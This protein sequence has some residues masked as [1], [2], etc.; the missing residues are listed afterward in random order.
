MY[1]SAAFVIVQAASL[2]FEALHLGTWPLTVVVVSAIVGFPMVLV[3]AWTF[4]FSSEG[5][6]RTE[7]REAGSAQLVQ[8]RGGLKHDLLLVGVVAAA[9]L[10]MGWVGWN[11]WLEPM[12]GGGAEAPAEEHSFDPRRMAVSYFEDHSP[13]A[14]LGYLARGLT[15]ALIHELD[16]IE[17]LDV[18]SPNGVKRYRGADVTPDSVARALRIGS[19]VEGSIQGTKDQIRVRAQLL[20]A[21]T[22]SVLESV[23]ESRPLGELFALQDDVVARVVEALRTRLGSI[24]RQRER[25]R[26][27]ESVEAWTLLQ[28]AEELQDRAERLRD[29]GDD[30]AVR[31]RL[32]RADSLLRRAAVLDSGWAAPVVLRGHLALSR[33]DLGTSGPMTFDRDLLRRAVD[34]AEAA[35]ERSPGHLGALE[36]RGMA[37]LRMSLNPHGSKN[38]RRL[39]EEDLRTVVDED[40]SRARAW[41]GLSALLRREGRFAEASLAAER[42]FEADQYLTLSPTIESAVLRRQYET[43]LEL[44]DIDAAREWCLT[45]H[46]EFPALSWTT[47]CKLFTLAL[48]GEPNTDRAWA[49]FD[50]LIAVTSD[51]RKDF[52]RGVGRM[53]V[54]SVIARSARQVDSSASAR[55]GPGAA[56]GERTPPAKTL[57]DSAHAVIERAR[58]VGRGQDGLATW[59]NYYEAHAR[60]Q[61]EER[62][63]A[64]A[65]IRRYLEARPQDAD[66]LR[67]DWILGDLQSDPRFLQLLDEVSGSS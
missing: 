19:L 38:V 64:L 10:G 24:V 62:D 48:A 43:N 52:N 16:R 46:R 51:P 3:V 40:A 1:A 14:D 12:R 59:L 23:E 67:V 41:N 54:A 37:R 6:K 35:L 2:T 44:A 22:G 33:A 15:D 4:E 13:D 8:P 53:W 25:Q 5:L 27:T 56:T 39:A 66:H 9:S 31:S 18:V 32:T 30:R 61:L 65:L 63:S 17:P 47:A 58:G 29:A 36:L 50:S 21:N 57:A 11:L 28:R 20:D 26:E 7:P 42:A 34:L 55:F 49:L 45:A 60:L